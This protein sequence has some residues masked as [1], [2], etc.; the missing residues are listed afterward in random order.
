L[1]LLNKTYNENN[2]LRFEGSFKAAVEEYVEAK[3]FSLALTKK[4]LAE[5]KIANIGPE[6]YIG[7][8]ADVPGELVRYAIKSA[9]EREFDIVKKCYQSAE[10]IVG[11]LIDMDLTGYN[12]QKFDQA[13]QALSKLQQ[14]VYEVEMKKIKNIE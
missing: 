4:N 9:T 3:M 10:E 12:R 6:E 13:K 2:R 8:L 11:V 1:S 5:L 14:V 7:G